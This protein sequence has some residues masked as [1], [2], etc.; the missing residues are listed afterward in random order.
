LKRILL[1]CAEY[2]VDT[3]YLPLP[4]VTVTS[5]DKTQD[6]QI[7]QQVF[8]SIREFLLSKGPESIKTFQFLLPGNKSIASQFKKVL[9]VMES[10]FQY[11]EFVPYLTVS[12][13]VGSPCNTRIPE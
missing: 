5:D 6:E 12:L 1:L 4:L 7:M 3:I 10:V 13:I 9:N 11:D 8:R 2:D